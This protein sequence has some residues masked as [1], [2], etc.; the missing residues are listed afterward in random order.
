MPQLTIPKD[1]KRRQ[2]FEKMLMVEDANLSGK[3]NKLKSHMKAKL[4]QRESV[5]SDF[6]V[7]TRKV[8]GLQLDD[9]VARDPLK[10]VLQLAEHGKSYEPDFTKVREINL[11][12]DF[13][14]DQRM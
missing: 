14:A 3:V 13:S 1:A 11:A 12:Q 5:T 9:H 10:E 7:I 6:D 8:R 4:Q 2:N